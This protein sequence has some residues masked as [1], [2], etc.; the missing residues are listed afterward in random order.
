MA[1]EFDVPVFYRSPIISRVK[2]ARR[3]DDPRKRDLAPSVLD[4]GAVRF[5]IG[6]HFGFCY[7]VENAIEIAYRAL[8]E[9]PEKASAGRIFLLSEMIHNPHVNEDLERRGIRFL[10]TTT[11]QQLIPFDEL[12]SE[13]IVIIPAFGTT[14]EIEADL[15]E[16][17]IEPQTYN[18]TCPFVEKVWKKSTQIGR[19]DYTVV[20]HGKRFHEETRAT[21]SRAQANAPVVVVRDMDETEDLIRV[22]VGERDATFFFE[23]FADRYSTDFDPE[24]D[25]QRIGV[26]NQTTMLASETAAIAERLRQAMITRFGEAELSNHFA[27]TSDTLCYATKENQDATIAVIEDGADL[28]IV[29]GGYNSSN[30]SHLVDLCEEEMPTFFVSSADRITSP[31]EIHHFDWHSKSEIESN[32]WLPEKKDRPLDILLTAGASCPDAL[33]DEVI[34]RVISWYPGALAVDEAL[35]P[36]AADAA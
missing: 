31:D 25:L 8:E 34:Q 1:R 35:A 30:T 29:V 21:F 28:A 4:F 7:G 23:Q 18:T 19:Q 14:R 27:D 2:E 22:V 17:G 5:K 33:L 26:V 13:D 16:R 10:R 20:V 15:L 6:R 3:I 36:F 24:R 11:G 12:R 32:N 9:H